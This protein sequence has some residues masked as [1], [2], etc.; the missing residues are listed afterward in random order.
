MKI[1]DAFSPAIATAT[2]TADLKKAA[3]A[4]EAVFLRQLIGTMRAAK[5]ADDVFGS[6]AS[7]QFRE[8][9]DAETAKT[10]A[11]LG[12]FGIATLIEKQLGRKA[13]S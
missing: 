9:A 13:A 10:M 5:L 8:M 6:E 4:F 12:Q 3:Q 2:S 7:G 1:S 11:G